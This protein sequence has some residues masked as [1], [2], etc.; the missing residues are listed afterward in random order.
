MSLYSP[1]HL[2]SEAGL[3]CLHV[4]YWCWEGVPS[5]WRCLLIPQVFSLPCY[6]LN[7]SFVFHGSLPSGAWDDHVVTTDTVVSIACSVRYAA[8]WQ[9]MCR[10]DL[11]AKTTWKLSLCPDCYLQHFPKFQ[12]LWWIHEERSIKISRWGCLDVEWVMQRKKC[13]SAIGFRFWLFLFIWGKFNVTPFSKK[14]SKDW[15]V[16]NASTCCL[17][18]V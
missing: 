2:D 9:K 18:I 17:V 8:V 11:T 1:Y 15:Y 6:Q 4:W 7:P 12:V 10:K 16:V 5:P 3:L 14:E 13:L